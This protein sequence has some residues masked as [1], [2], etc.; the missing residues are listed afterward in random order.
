MAPFYDE[1]GAPDGYRI[2][3]IQPG[4]TW[5]RLGVQDGDVIRRVNGEPLDNPDRCLKVWLDALRG[6]WFDIEIDRGG[7]SVLNVVRLK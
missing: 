4:S 7:R 5:R 6:R 2:W 3:G 1:K